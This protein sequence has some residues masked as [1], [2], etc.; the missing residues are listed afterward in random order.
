LPSGWRSGP[1][2]CDTA[3]AAQEGSLDALF[4]SRDRVAIH[5]DDD[6]LLI[7]GYEN[8][9]R[10]LVCTVIEYVGSDRIVCDDEFSVGHRILVPAAAG[11]CA[12][13]QRDHESGFIR[14]T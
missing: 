9:S 8:K 14:S 2:L 5:S 4:Q 11:L 7:A 12:S 13:G 3:I 1:Q 6:A 10:R